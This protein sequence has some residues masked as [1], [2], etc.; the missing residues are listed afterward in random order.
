MGDETLRPGMVYL[1]DPTVQ[2]HQRPLIFKLL[3][4]KF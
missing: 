2:N 4:P 3:F 1:Y